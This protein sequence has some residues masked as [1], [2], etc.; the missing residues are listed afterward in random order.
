MPKLFQLVTKFSGYR[1]KVDPTNTDPGV[2]VR[3][4]QNC[5]TSDGERIA[6][7]KGY[8]L[9]GST[10][11]STLTPIISS[12]EWFNRY[13]DER[14]LRT[15]GAY[16]QM[17]YTDGEWYYLMSGLTSGLTYNFAPWWDPSTS[18]ERLLFVNGT[19]NIYSW[20]GGTATFAS[21]TV[22]TITKEGTAT[23]T[24][25]GFINTGTRSVIINGGT[26]TYTGGESTT[27]L[28]GVSPD[29][30]AP[31]FAVG[32]LIIAGVQVVANITTTGLPTA[33]PNDLIGVYNNHVFIG[34][35]TYR[36][37]Y[38]SK[39]TSYTDFSYSSPRL[40]AEGGLVTL[41]ATPNAFIV[42]EENMYISAGKN[43]WYKAIFRPSTDNTNEAFEIERLKTSTQKAAVG[44]GGVEN[45]INDIAFISNE[46]TFDLLGRIDQVS[47]TPQNKALS[48][49]IKP[50]FDR[51]DFTDCHV[52]Y[53]KNFVYIAVPREGLLL[54]YNIQKEW[55]EPPQIL[56]IGRLAIIGG[57]L[58]GHSSEVPETYKLFNGRNDKDNPIDAHARF[59]YQNFGD[60][61]KLKSF[62]EWSTEGY[63]SANTL[64][65]KT[66]YYEYGGAEG[67]PYVDIDGSDDS[68]LFSVSPDY[69]LGTHSLGEVSLG[70]GGSDED[71]DLPPKFRHI[72]EVV[73]QD[74]FEIQVEYSTNEVDQ[75]WELLA[76][77]PSVSVSNADSVSIKN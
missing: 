40:A 54:L 29:P 57:A 22:N 65:R 17:R 12:T 13:G 56:P 50:D 27:T 16:I 38:M 48:D 43:F 46:P 35:E 53:F 18:I 76:F 73:R 2:L 61:V 34:S 77:G 28:T 26:Y 52:K 32:T 6:I 33:F 45:A 10:N 36:S 60:R 5:L 7:R 62:T 42:Q 71:D 58:Y 8:T 49:P 31:A 9:D 44:Q 37:V 15:F 66:M 67:N 14:P 55:W 25:S 1:T 69:S 3:G 21:A 23:W 19:S 59:S 24:E 72:D 39:S 63:I 70:G 47:I 41:D 4:S 30:S 51:Y 11:D 75:N 74:F 68:I 64:L 20:T